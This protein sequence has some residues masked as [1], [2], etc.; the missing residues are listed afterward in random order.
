MGMIGSLIKT[1]SGRW[2]V[3][4]TEGRYPHFYRVLFPVDPDQE[5]IEENIDEWNN[6]VAFSTRYYRNQLYAFIYDGN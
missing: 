5:V 6:L 1:R 2:M 4:Y 3:E